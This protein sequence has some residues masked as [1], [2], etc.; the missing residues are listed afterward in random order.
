MLEMFN[1]MWGR[2]VQRS[3]GGMERNDPGLDL[4][5]GETSSKLG[6]FCVIQE[7]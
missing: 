6:F 5:K 4:C 7:E 2:M 3:G 1:F